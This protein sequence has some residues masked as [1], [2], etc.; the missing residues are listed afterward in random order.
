MQ[1]HPRFAKMVRE[2]VLSAYEQGYGP[3]TG[4]INWKAIWEWFLAN[5]PA[6]LSLL[7]KLLL[8]FL[9]MSKKGK[10]RWIN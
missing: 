3:I 9:A 1:D 4:A 5:A 2:Q 8:V 6:I 10:K 7:L